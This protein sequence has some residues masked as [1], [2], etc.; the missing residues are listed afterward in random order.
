MEVRK[1]KMIPFFIYQYHPFQKYILTCI[2]REMKKGF[3]EMKIDLLCSYDILL[4]N[5]HNS[6][7]STC[8]LSTS[9][10]FYVCVHNF[11]T[12]KTEREEKL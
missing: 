6:S 12:K 4:L 9:H 11:N 10:K 8:T 3:V 7:P 2:L 1:S 5:V